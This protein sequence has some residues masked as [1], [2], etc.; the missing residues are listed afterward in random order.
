MA[1]LLKNSNVSSARNAYGQWQSFSLGLGKLTGFTP[2]TQKKIVGAPYLGE[3]GA[4]A[5]NNWYKVATG[6]IQGLTGLYDEY[7][8]QMD[9]EVDKYLKSHSKED[10]INHIKSKGL[11]FQNDPVAMN[12]FKAKYANVFSGMVSNEFQGKID[13]G[14]FQ[15]KTETEIDAEYFRFAQ[16]KLRELSEATGGEFGGDTFNKAFFA[17]SPQKRLLA[18]KSQQ[19]REQNIK[20]SKDMMANT[21]LIQTGLNDG[22]INSAESFENAL[23]EVSTTTGYHYTP[24]QWK[25]F[26]DSSV[27]LIASSPNGIKILKD[28]KGKPYFGLNGLTYDNNVIETKIA[29][30]AKLDADRN[31]EEYYA[32]ERNLAGLVINGDMGALD[33]LAQQNKVQ[34]GNVPNPKGDMI[35]KA[36]IDCMKA[37]ERERNKLT[38]QQRA[39]EKYIAAIPYIDSFIHDSIKGLDV[40]KANAKI[41]NHF[42]SS[43][44]DQR[45]Q[46][47]LKEERLTDAQIVGFASNEAVSQ[48]QNINPAVT[49]VSALCTRALTNIRAYING[50]SKELPSFGE[51]DKKAYDKLVTWYQ[52]NPNILNITQ[53]YN[54][55]EDVQITQALLMGVNSGMSMGE[56]LDQMRATKLLKDP[57]RATL[58]QMKMA[59]NFTDKVVTT[60]GNDAYSANLLINA[61]NIAILYGGASASTALYQAQVNVASS[62][63]LVGTSYVPK[64]FLNVLD[65]VSLV[66]NTAKELNK[67]IHEKF[68]NAGFVE[69]YPARNCLLVYEKNTG[70]LLKKVTQDD[71]LKVAQKGQEETRKRNLEESR[72][73]RRLAVLQ[74]GSD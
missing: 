4:E 73:N 43:Q 65:D 35:N 36:R 28:L 39:E 19:T 9:T 23:R 20:V 47:L 56:V 30:A 12:I 58:E 13:N 37:L 42:T 25:K 55:N 62:H 11:P 46:Q 8:K 50:T 1:S 59:K 29:Q 72:V 49:Y 22:T 10:Y 71:V 7:S 15:G 45:F 57:K 60:V 68:P 64:M 14:D 3:V 17:D 2:N 67:E 66:D 51:E 24:E 34:Y 69:F 52:I 38:E 53:K 74:G 63:S 21:A 32:F 40:F 33:A 26:V 48:G 54:A 44:L 70:R 5:E 61:G 6:T 16:E 31:A 41:F 27:D 18:M